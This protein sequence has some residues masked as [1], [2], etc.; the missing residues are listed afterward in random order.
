LGRFP[1]AKKA[2]NLIALF[3]RTHPNHDYRVEPQAVNFTAHGDLW[4]YLFD[5]HFALPGPAGPLFIPWTL[6]M[7]SWRWV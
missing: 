3:A 7:G 6:E 5:L 4:D 2:R 1:R